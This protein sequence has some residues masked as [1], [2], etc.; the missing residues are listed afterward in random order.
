LINPNDKSIAALFSPEENRFPT[1]VLDDSQMYALE[2]LGMVKD[3]LC[4]REICGRAKSIEKLAI[5]DRGSALRRSQFLIKYLRRNIERLKEMDKSGSDLLQNIKF[6]PVRLTPPASY[7]LSWKGGEFHTIEFRSPDEL[8]LLKDV[9]L[10]GS[11]CLIVDD[12][13]QSGC[14]HMEVLGNVLG[15]SHRRPSCHQVLQQLEITRESNADDKTNITV[16]KQVYKHLNDELAKNR[17]VSVITKLK[18]TAWLFLHG[19]FVE[20]RKIALEWK[21]YAVPFLYSVPDEYKREFVELLKV[22]GIKEIFRPCDFLEAL[23]SL[24]G[25]K[26]DSRLTPEDIKLVVTLI[27]ELRY[28]SDDL[29]KQRVGTIPLPDAQGVLC[30]SKDLTIPERFQVKYVGNERYI[31]SDINRNIA[32]KLGAKPLRARRREKYGKTMSMSF[33]QFEKL[34]DRIKNI[35]ESY[36]RDVGILKELVQN[37]DDA[38]AT[39]VQFIYDKRTLP[40]KRVLQTNA[41]EIQGPALCVYNNKYFSEDDLN[42]ICKLGIGSKRDD[43]AKTGQYGIGFNAVYHLTDC[44]SFLSDDNTLCILDPHCEYSPEST[45]EAPGGRYNNIDHDFKDIFSDTVS[46]YT[47][48]TSVIIFLCKAPLCFDFH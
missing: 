35:L 20:Y 44:P 10:I 42:G 43:P 15:F 23:D 27:N 24:Q 4:W 46:G 29:V 18:N 48:E 38:K 7:T 36:P 30:N 45:Q 31:H 13:E 1:G 28:Q 34:T 12:T 47:L 16:C 11:S 5:K 3:L 8:F 19:T 41:N 6:L 26:Q 9:N 21:G 39:E 37:A 17:D 40:H 32:L 14:G 33:G 25:S 22:T 2:K